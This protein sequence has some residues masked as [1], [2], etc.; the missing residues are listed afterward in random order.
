MLVS[1]YMTRD[2]VCVA[3][4]DDVVEA[5]ARMTEVGVRCLPV[6]DAGALRGIVSR[7]DVLR[8]AP[9][10]RHPFA[11]EE[12]A[13]ESLGIRIEDIMVGQVVTVAPDDSIESAVRLLDL[14][15]LHCV[16]VLR[17][18]RVVGLLSR[19]DIL[20][21]FR[22][23]VFVPTA[24]LLSLVAPADADVVEHFLGSG[25]SEVLRLRAYLE[26]RRGDERLIELALEGDE[27]AS[28][29]GLS[30]AQKAGVRLLTRRQPVPGSDS[31]TAA[32]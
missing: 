3:P 22:E 19:S 5:V 13:R 26:Q 15:K 30:L 8:T 2:P 25:R 7:S 20:R 6:V 29:A 17:G 16:P 9:P 31:P 10:N 11:P 12:R 21:A 28:E 14:N 24:V 4:D 27:A 18:S 1:I 32:V 23:I